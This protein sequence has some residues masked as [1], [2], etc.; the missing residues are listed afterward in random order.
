MGDL[1]RQRLDDR[2]DRA[3]V[4]PVAVALSGGSD[5][6]ALTLVAAEWAIANR[7]RLL[8]LT[9]DHGLQTVSKDWTRACGATAA[10]LGAEFQALTWTGPHPRSGVPAAARLARHR[11]LAQAARAAGARVLLLGHTADDLAEAALMRLGGTATPSPREW[12]PSPVWPEGRGLFLLRPLLG[13]RRDALRQWLRARGETWIEDPANTDMRFA[14]SRARLALADL[15]VAT[16]HAPQAPPVTNMLRDL[17]LQVE[18]PVHGL[19]LDRR[20]LRESLPAAVRRIVAVACLSVSGG[21]R[22][23]RGE[24]LDRL[25]QRLRSK[26]T[27][28][29]CLAGALVTADPKSVT[30]GR[31]AGEMGRRGVADLSLQP[32]CEAVF[33]GRFLVKAQREVR[34]SPLAGGLSLLPE[35]DRAV[36]RTVPAAFRGGLPGTLSRDGFR[37]AGAPG[38]GT[39]ILP[40][41]GARL[42]AACDA[43]Q[44]EATALRFDLSPG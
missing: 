4:A 23:P 3:S 44:D 43:I 26:E 14:R 2:L 40:L 16:P 22:P 39:E 19:I 1:V 27:V 17:A 18:T 13:L 6:L 7:R 34:L 9:V 21:D 8:I 5:S 28:S 37:L 20:T 41:A 15:R 31:T 35:G 42:L 32:G 29:A 25:V 10:R 11:L 33:D 38:S 36:L 12:A 24:A 30:W